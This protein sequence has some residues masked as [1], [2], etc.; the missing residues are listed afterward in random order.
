[1]SSPETTAPAVQRPVPAPSPHSAPFWAAAREH[2]LVLQ[3]CQACGAIQHYP[4]PWCTTCL[5]EDLGWVE[6]PGLGTLY[7]F[8]VIRRTAHPAFAPL[9]PYVYGL[10]D[11]DEGPRL[12]TNIVGCPVE[13]VAIGM[14]VRVRFE[15]VD[16][17]GTLVLFAPDA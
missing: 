17:A 14:R 12:T 9:V 4:R 13:D 10:V 3:R 15:D 2:R 6:S 7:S 5:S 8:T 11:L 16:G 1:V